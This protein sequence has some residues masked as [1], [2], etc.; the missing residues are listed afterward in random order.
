MSAHIV[1]SDLSVSDTDG[2]ISIGQHTH[3]IYFM[4]LNHNDYVEIKLNGGPHKIYVRKH[5]KLNDYSEFIGDYTRFQVM[6]AGASV[7]VYAIG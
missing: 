5:D 1:Y 6:T 2:E 3:A 4:N 7:A